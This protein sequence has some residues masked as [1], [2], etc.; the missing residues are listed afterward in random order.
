MYLLKNFFLILSVTLF[1]CD[2]TNAQNAVDTLQLEYEHYKLKNGIEVILQPEQDFDEVSVEFWIRSGSK[3][4]A[5]EKYGLAHFFEHVTPYGLR[6]NPDKLSLLNE[7]FYTGSNAQTKKDYTR[8]NLKVKPDGIDLALQYIAERIK[9]NPEDITEKKINEERVRVINEIERN[10]IN[11]F[12]SA[13]G[14]MAIE[15]ATFGE[16]HP[17]GHNGYG[18]IENNKSFTL[19]DFHQWF[20]DHMYPKNI[21]LFVVGDFHLEETKQLIKYNFEDIPVS[22][23]KESP[24]IP[25]P[26]NNFQHILVVTNSDH[27]YLSFTWAIPGWGTTEEAGFRLLSNILDERLENEAR[28]SSIIS[29]ANSSRL[30]NIHQAAGQFG[31]HASFS[32]LKDSISVEQLLID[33]VQDLVR[34]G[35]TQLELSRAKQK[36]ITK[37]REMEK[38]IGFQYSRTELLGESLLFKNDPNFYFI[39]LKEQMSLNENE[40][41]KLAEDWLSNMSSKI[42]F[43]SKEP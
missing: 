20:S 4:E 28:E 30:L 12:W 11:P 43:I 38:N 15:K 29:D 10:S 35:V 1:L 27:N 3:N 37:I 23:G 16:N 26:D 42:L 32:F 13:D 5:S 14:G 8:Y 41:N 7:T 33:T 36:E 21:I 2:L 22:E 31:I 34:N 18:T 40:V 24:Q 9:A 6:D 25:F 19:K 39:R 17:Y